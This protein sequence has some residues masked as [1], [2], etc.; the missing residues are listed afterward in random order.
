MG[1]SGVIHFVTDS[2]NSNAVQH[3][4]FLVYSF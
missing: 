1:N 2:D 3:Y 4:L